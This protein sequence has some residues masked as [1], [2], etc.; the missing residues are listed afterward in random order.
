M[1]ESRL[2]LYSPPDSYPERAAAGGVFRL[3]HS[4]CCFAPSAQ[5]ESHSQTL[6]T[7]Q[8]QHVLVLGYAGP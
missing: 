6:E 5:R 3:E 4:V 8:S 1:F 2:N 7:R